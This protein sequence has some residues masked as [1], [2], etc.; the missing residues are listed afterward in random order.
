M[1]ISIDEEKA[2]PIVQ[3]ALQ[4]QGAPADDAAVQAAMGFLSAFEGQPIPLD[5]PLTLKQ[6]NGAWKVCDA[7]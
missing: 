5:Q 7:A 3:A 1:T 2:K 6:E 4:A